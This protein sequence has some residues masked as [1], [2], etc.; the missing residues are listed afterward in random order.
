MMNNN[1]THVYLPLIFSLVLITGIIL[2]IILANPSK[3]DKNFLN[4]I[5]SFKLNSYKSNNRIK[6][7]I[8]YV[9]RVYVDSVSKEQLSEYAIN[10]MLQNLDPHSCYIPASEFN[11]VNDPLLGNFEGIGIKFRIQKDTVTVLNVIHGGPSEKNGIKPG[12]RIVKIEGQNVAGIKITN[13]KVIKKLK[14][15][16]GTKANINIS[17][18]GIS[19]LMDFTITRD[20][21]NTNS[22]DV[23]YMVTSNIGYIKISKFSATTYDEFL[24]DLLKL[25]SKGLKK[26]IIDI[27]GNGGGYLNI[28]TQLADEFLTDKKL[29][30]YTQG[31]NSPK[32]YFYASDKGDFKKN[33]LVV[34]IDELSASASEILAG[35]IQDND[36][37]LI[38]GRRS[39]G[40]GLVQEQ[41][42]FSDGSAMR[43]TTARYYTPLGRCIQRPYKN[44]TKEYYNDFYKKLFYDELGNIDSTNLNDSLKYTT[45]KGKIVYGGGG[46]M[47]DIYVPFDIEGDSKYLEKLISKGLIYQF[48]FDYADKNRDKLNHFKTYKDYKENFVITNSIVHNF[49]NYANKNEVEKDEKG[50]YISKNVIKIRLKAYIGRDILDDKGFYPVINEIDKT[51]LKAVEV[52]SKE[53]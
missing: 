30:V 25:K 19:K 44:G 40:K 26:L 20:V 43:L 46:I 10:G 35:A 49:I 38:I 13:E 9:E 29:I 41:I 53:K 36:R 4:N 12:D 7:V 23:A 16:K 47:P 32:K 11:K 6:D 1:K 51:F 24:S 17:R 34:L 48:A 28:A 27:R 42:E 31:R 18:I 8:N 37:G 3:T 21:I 2:G 50:L 45:P 5:F 22:I 52:L 39:F 15:K 14:G 33:E